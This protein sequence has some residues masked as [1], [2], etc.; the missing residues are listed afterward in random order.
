MS[1]LPKLGPICPNDLG[2]KAAFW[3]GKDGEDASF[4]RIL[5][6]VTV[7]N[8]IETDTEPCVA[9]VLSTD[10]GPVFAT[11]QNFPDFVGVYENDATSSQVIEAVKK[12]Q[13]MQL[14]M[15]ASMMKK[16]MGP[17]G[18]GGGGAGP[19]PPSTGASPLE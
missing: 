9:L 8:Y 13:Q 19:R 16:P 7:S 11:T 5:G 6:W 17:M 1:S 12:R 10:G 3:S 2:L 15:R 4:R 18:G 14:Q